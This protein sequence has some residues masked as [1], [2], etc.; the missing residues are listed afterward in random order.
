MYYISCFSIKGRY[1]YDAGVN[2]D[3]REDRQKEK[4]TIRGEDYYILLLWSFNGIAVITDYRYQAEVAEVQTWHN[5]TA[6]WNK[7][8]TQTCIC[9]TQPDEKK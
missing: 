3:K 6:K 9:L 7:G 4:E 5:T 2:A 8:E 1:H